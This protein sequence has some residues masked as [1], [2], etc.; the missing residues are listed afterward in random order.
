ME[1]NKEQTIAQSYAIELLHETSLTAAIIANEIGISYT[2]FKRIADGVT[3]QPNYL[4]FKKLV[5]FYC[6]VFL[7]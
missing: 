6:R 7:H 5:N 3:K 1:K 2:C 4:T